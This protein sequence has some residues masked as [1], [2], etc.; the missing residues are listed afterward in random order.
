MYSGD[1]RSEKCFVSAR[2][3]ARN[4]FFVWHCRCGTLPFLRVNEWGTARKYGGAVVALPCPQ[5]GQL[6]GSLTSRMR[7]KDA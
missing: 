1:G 7:M 3:L 2:K 4:A 6:L 5:W